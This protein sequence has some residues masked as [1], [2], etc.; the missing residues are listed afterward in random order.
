MLQLNL[1]FSVLSDQLFMTFAS[2]PNL[3]PP[4]TIFRIN[5]RLLSNTYTT[6]LLFK[7]IFMTSLQQKTWEI[8]QYCKNY[9]IVLNVLKQCSWCQVGCKCCQQTWLP[10]PLL[11]TLCFPLQA[12]AVDTLCY[13]TD[14]CK[15]TDTRWQ[16]VPCLHYHHIISYRTASTQDGQIITDYRDNG[17]TCACV[18]Q[19]PSRLLQQSTVRYKRQLA[20][21][22]AGSSECCSSC[23]DKN[24]EVR[25]H[26]AS[27]AWTSLACSSQA[28]CLQAG[29]D[30]L[31][32]CARI[33]ATIPGCRLCAGH[34]GGKL[35]TAAICSVL[36]PRCH[37]DYNNTWQKEL[38]I[39]WS[40]NLEQ[41]SG[42][43]ATPITVTAD[44]WT[45]T[46]TVFVSTMSAPEEFLFLK[47][48][49]TNV[50]IIIII[51]AA[52]IVCLLLGRT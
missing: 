28:H 51:I 7:F 38:R 4:S 19:Q 11:R 43:S 50:L 52:F 36:L 20:E 42:R 24:Q 8:K 39:Q 44:I 31:Q 10:P 29:G 2:R 12:H 40:K 32:V 9:W 47:L 5:I 27:L 22:A 23:H 41:S 48:R 34:L 35:T 18:R 25:P 45:K 21:E 14:L 13:N 33:G 30:G 15:Q 6:T 17:D 3:F 26:H 37:W 16:H 49:Y 46:E 1:F